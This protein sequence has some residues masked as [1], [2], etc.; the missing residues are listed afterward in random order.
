MNRLRYIMEPQSL[1]LTWQPVDESSPTRTRRVVASVRRSQANSRE[2]EFEY[3]IGTEDWDAAVEAGFKGHPAFKWTG[4]HTIFRSG[5]RDT[6]IRRLPP[7]N[8]EDFPEFLALHRLPEP[9]HYSEMALLGYTGAK[10]PSDGFSLAPQ[11]SQSSQPCEYVLEVAGARHVFAG[12]LMDIRIGDPVELRLEPLNPVDEDAIA[13]YHHEVKLGY[14]NRAMRSTF[15]N[16][17]EHGQLE[18]A[19]ERLNGK[20]ERPLIY[21][22]IAANCSLAVPY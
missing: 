6:L 11:F 16:W 7:L 19:I 2:W 18:G 9:F 20:P 1:L 14:V 5:V 10:L 4:A 21:V 8:R 3:L 12:D 17:L 13:L 15:L 22:R